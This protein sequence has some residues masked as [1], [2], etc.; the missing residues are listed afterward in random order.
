M[1]TDILKMK[2]T[3]SVAEPGFSAGEEASHRQRGSGQEGNHHRVV[4]GTGSLLRQQD[5]LLQASPAAPAAT[6]NYAL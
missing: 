6:T 3:P 2:N 5:C 1:T 4:L